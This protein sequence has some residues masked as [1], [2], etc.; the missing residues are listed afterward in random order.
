MKLER[1]RI[2]RPLIEI[3]AG[4]ANGHVDQLSLS[5]GFL[6]LGQEDKG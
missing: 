4:L 3:S 2:S 1:Q 6:G 5:R